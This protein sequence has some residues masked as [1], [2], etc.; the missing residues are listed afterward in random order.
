MRDKG[1]LN[2]RLNM[3]NIERLEKMQPEAASVRQKTSFLT[4]HRTLPAALWASDGKMR[5]DFAPYGAIRCAG[6]AVT[7][8]FY[9]LR[10]TTLN[11]P[12]AFLT[13]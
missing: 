6:K 8:G 5:R 13:R 9:G 3:K 4:E 1:C 2:T 11:N 12:R 10:V 7:A